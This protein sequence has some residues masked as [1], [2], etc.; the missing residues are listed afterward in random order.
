[1]KK[2]L[3]IATH[4]KDRSP[5]QRFRF[6]QYFNYLKENGFNCKLSYLLSEKEDKIFYQKGHYLF[7]AYLFIK[8]FIKRV[9]EAMN[10][11]QHDIV[12]LYREAHMAGNIFIEKLYKKSNVKLIFDF[13]DSIWI[14]D[15]S[16]G[17]KFFSWLKNPGK[18]KRIVSL[19]DMVF[20]GNQYLANYASK[21]NN[22]VKVIPTTIDT[23]EY[24]S[25]ERNNQSETVCIGWSGSITTIKH[26]EYIIPALLKLKKKYSSK[27]N[28]KVI[29]DGQYKNESLNISGVPW[30]KNSEIKDLAE[31]DIGIM[32]LPDDAWSK[33]KCGLKGLQYM[34]LG[35][36][37]VLSPVGVN[38]EI[39]QDGANGF[40]AHNEEEW[41]QKLS[42]LIENREL[43]KKIGKAGRKTVVEKY[44]VESQKEFYLQYLNE[45]FSKSSNQIDKN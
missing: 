30:Q 6:E 7:K 3:F 36:P 41:I 12:F 38:V 2:I 13:D 27:I 24:V 43:R 23:N 29:G 32:P 40:I 8:Y 11:S 28:F 10:I 25:V 35:I 20:V 42:L 26:F 33:G 18:I 19:S 17:N 14:N 39:I 15:T 21:Y 1:M 45:L 31:I 34:A 16:A 37:S 44:S 4:R 9:W 5:G 22:N